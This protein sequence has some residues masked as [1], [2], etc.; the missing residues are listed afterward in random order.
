MSYGIKQNFH[1]VYLLTCFKHGATSS[2]IFKCILEQHLI[3]EMLN[4][5]FGLS[6]YPEINIKKSFHYK[7]FVLVQIGQISMIQ[8][9]ITDTIVTHAQ[10]Q[11][12][13]GQKVST[14]V[15]HTNFKL[16]NRKNPI[17]LHF[18]KFPHSSLIR[19]VI[20]LISKIMIKRPWIMVVVINL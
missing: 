17:F 6:R 9:L 16:G 20:Y 1:K 7:K 14:I 11:H 5:V 19:C 2:E 3:L 15:C 12:S 18:L 13:N 4:I 8:H 10:S